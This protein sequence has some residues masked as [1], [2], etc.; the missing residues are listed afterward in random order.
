[1]VV[2]PRDAPELLLGTGRAPVTPHPHPTCRPGPVWGIPGKAFIFADF[3]RVRMPPWHEERGAY[4]AGVY[5]LELSSDLTTFLHLGF[6]GFNRAR[7]LQ[8]R[9]VT[10]AGLP[11]R[12]PRAVGP[13]G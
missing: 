10:D 7:G 11:R 3:N 8:G 12:L 1:M 5:T 2:L 6:D 13:D 4:L 9:P